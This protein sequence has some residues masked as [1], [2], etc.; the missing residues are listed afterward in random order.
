MI[1][2]STTQYEFAHGKMPRGRG[3]WAFFFDGRTNVEDAFWSN[4]NQLYS[5]ALND[6]K[7]YAAAKG[8][9]RIEV[10]S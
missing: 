9:S 5:Q 3:M 4:P 8:Y 7:R 10:G 2:V 1:T 6:A